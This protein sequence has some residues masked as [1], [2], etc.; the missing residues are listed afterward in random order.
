EVEEDVGG[1]EYRRRLCGVSK[2]LSLNPSPQQKTL[3]KGTPHLHPLLPS[4]PLRAERRY[5]R[6]LHFLMADRLV[7]RA[8]STYALSS[9]LNDD[10]CAAP[11]RRCS[12]IASSSRL[13]IPAQS[14]PR[15]RTYFQID[16]LD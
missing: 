6:P 2:N 4:A 7:H 9:V 15:L 12:G 5:F 3:W 13:A 1:G 14:S 11:P 10:G 16:A 8:G